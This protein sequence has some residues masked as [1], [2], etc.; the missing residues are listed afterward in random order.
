MCKSVKACEEVK[1]PAIR[2]AKRGA[3]GVGRGADASTS[4]GAA[5]SAP[6]MATRKSGDGGSSEASLGEDK[7]AGLDFGTGY[8]D[9]ICAIRTVD[10]PEGAAYLGLKL[11]LMGRYVMSELLEMNLLRNSARADELRVHAVMGGGRPHLRKL[12]SVGVGAA[13]SL[14]VLAICAAAFAPVVHGQNQAGAATSGT[15]PAHSQTSSAA[16]NSSGT[17]SATSSA[18]SPASAGSQADA[19]APQN[20][21]QTG[22]QASAPKSTDASAQSEPQM[23][24][25][26]A[27]PAESLGEAARR[28]RAQKA[29]SAT[30]KVYSDDSVATLSGHGVSVVGDGQVGDGSSYSGGAASGGGAQGSGASQES[31]WRGR[32]N[33]IRSQMA[34]CDQKISEIQDEIAKHGAV[35]VD[36]MSGAQAGVIFVEDRNAQIKQVEHQK[37]GL[38]SQLEALEEEGRK[39]GADS[40]W[41]R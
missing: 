2:K 12:G 23:Q 25:Q 40:G 41:F 31:Y 3:P 18:K 30:A 34:Q 38:Q 22:A 21:T 11:L 16:G 15:G 19:A 24:D 8:R 28:A 36:P 39:A 17:S 37:D 9:D 32:A 1:R 4:W 7:I 29:K 20:S 5:S 26:S 35:S 13:S 33:A 10:P 27:P 14:L 6:T